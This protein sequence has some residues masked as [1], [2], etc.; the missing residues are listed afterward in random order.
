MP[1]KDAQ[2]RDSETKIKND[3]QQSLNQASRRDHHE[4]ESV[5]DRYLIFLLGKETYAAPLLSVLEVIKVGSIKTVP[6]TRDHF[7]GVLNLRGQIISIVD[8]RARF[9]IDEDPDSPGLILVIPHQDQV[10]GMLVDDV[11]AVD[12]IPENELRRD[13]AVESHIPIE[14]LLAVAHRRDQLVSV[15]DLT[16]V[17]NQSEI[18]SIEQQSK[19]I[20]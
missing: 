8:L 13:F 7:V 20:A 18:I 3:F 2:A 12:R 14:F 6:H 16:R 15:V 1:H 10:F 4:D 11:R 19:N 5:E 9:G 17:L